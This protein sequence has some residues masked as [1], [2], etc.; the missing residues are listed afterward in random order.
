MRASS[1]GCDRARG[2]IS[3]ELD[4]ELSEFESM[5][6]HA[7]LD[8]CASCGTF[9]RETA[10]FT[11]A[12]REAPLELASRPFAVPRKSRRAL[13]P[14]RVPAVAS[15]VIT[16]IAA[17]SLLASFHSNDLRDK[18]SPATGLITLNDG[19]LRQ[20]QLEKASSALAELRLRR[21][22]VMFSRIPRH[23]GFQN[24]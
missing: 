21:A 14:L 1:Q 24:P 15:L 22:Q 13:Q 17:A 2:W 23:P 6:M 16:A 12:L 4:G 20:L 9:R 5:L 19:G 7:H 11:A 8:R 3:A 18:Q 10:G